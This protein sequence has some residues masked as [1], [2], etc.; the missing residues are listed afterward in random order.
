MKLSEPQQQISDSES[1]MRICAAGRRFGKSFLAINE[2]AKFARHPNRKCLYVAP[3]YRMARQIIWEDLKNFLRNV[4]W[5]KR[6]NESELTIYL[7]NNSQIMLRSAD[8][9]DSIRGIGVDFLVLDE[10][11]D[12]PKLEDTWQAVLRPTLSDRQG[13]ALIIGSPKGRNFFYDMWVQGGATE[14]WQSFQFTTLQGLRV[15]QEEITAAKRD[16]DERTFQQEYEARFVDYAG[17][18]YYAFSDDNIKQFNPDDLTPRTPLHVGI[19]MNINPMSAV[20]G[21]ILGDMMHIIDE[22]EIYSSNTIELINE[23]KSRYPHRIILAYPDASGGSLKT[24]AAGMSDHLF[25]RNAG[26]TVKV[27]KTNPPIVD[28]INA[29]NSMLCNSN[30]ERKLLIDPKCKSLRN[31]LIKHTYKPGTRQPEK[32][33]ATDF[34]HM[35]DAL[36]YA[37]YQNFAIRREQLFDD[38]RGQTRRNTGRMVN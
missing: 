31:C 20:I 38:V 29:V 18:I 21:V 27:G 36:G 30:N 2:L 19:D 8:N 11:A 22:V 32:D 12:I 33:G 6:V 35:N 26:F 4:K 23:I 9:P 37:V 17:V 16:L 14:D 3:S 28:R 24:S 10:A 34:S 13:H 5:I 15:P 1:R 25:L 7:V